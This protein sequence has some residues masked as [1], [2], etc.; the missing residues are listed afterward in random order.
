MATAMNEE[1]KATMY[2]SRNHTNRSHMWSSD[3]LGHYL[4][5]LKE[6]VKRKRMSLGLPFSEK[7]LILCDAA[8]VHSAAMYE[9]LRRRFEQEAN[10]LLI[11][12]GGKDDEQDPRPRI[13]GGWGACGAPNDA[14]HQFFHYLRRGWMRLCCGNAA[15]LQLRRSLAEFDLSIDGNAKFQKLGSNFGI[16]SFVL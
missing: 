14:W 10:A 16:V 3:T 1:L 4:T 8:T 11:H 6:E 9:Q 13:P 5:F 7:A 15:S 2:I 12:G